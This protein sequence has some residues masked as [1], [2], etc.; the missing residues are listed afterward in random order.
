MEY[1]Q[2]IKGSSHK[3]GC[4]A[5]YG[6]NGTRTYARFWHVQ[7]LWNG[8]GVGISY[9]SNRYSKANNKYW[10]SRQKTYI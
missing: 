9:I 4:N 1:F 10:K 2:V 8:T 3:L 7:I 5:Y 6:K